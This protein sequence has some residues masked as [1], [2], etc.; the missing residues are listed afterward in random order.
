MSLK[1]HIEITRPRD[2]RLG[3]L[4]FQPRLQSKSGHG[5][6]GLGDRLGS[7]AGMYRTLG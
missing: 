1:E 5:L 7:A 6:R 4:L 2:P 3:D